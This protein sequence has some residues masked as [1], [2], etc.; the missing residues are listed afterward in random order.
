MLPLLVLPVVAMRVHGLLLPD[1]RPATPPTTRATRSTARRGVVRLA[2]VAQPL[3][4][5][6]QRSLF[7]TTPP[8]SS[9]LPTPLPPLLSPL[10]KWSQQASVLVPQ[11][12]FAVNGWCRRHVL[13]AAAVVLAAVW[14]RR[15]IT[16]ARRRQ[17][18]DMTSEWTRFSRNPGARGAALTVGLLRLVPLVIRA[19]LA[20]SEQAASALRSQAGEKLKSELIKLGPTYVKVGQIV[21]CRDE[22]L[23]KEYVKALSKLQDQVPAFDG[24]AAVELTVEAL[25]KPL[26]SVFQEFD[27]TPLAAASL[28]QVHRAV[29]T[30]EYQSKVV[31]VKVQRPGLKQMYDLD[32]GLLEKMVTVLDRFNVT[33]AGASQRWGDVF[34]EAKVILYREIDYR[35]EAANGERFRSNFQDDDSIIAPATVPELCTEK[36]LVMEYLPGIKAT[37]T[38]A[39]DKAGVNRKKVANNLAKAFMLQFCKH[40]FFN[41]DPHPGN[42]AVDPSNGRLIFYDFGQACSL[43]PLQSAGIQA[44]IESI[45]DLDASACVQAF[46]DMGI[47][48]EGANQTAIEAVVRN[49]FKTGAISS[50]A[51]RRRPFESS[52]SAD[53]SPTAVDTTNNTNSNTSGSTKQGKGSTGIVK[54]WSSSIMSKAEAARASKAVMPDIVLP[55]EYA[56][57]ARAL[58]QMDGVGKALDPDFEFIAAAAPSL[59]E[60]KGGGGVY[61][62][63][64]IEK[65]WWAFVKQFSEQRGWVRSR[66]S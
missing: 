65:K 26:K 56:F 52:A 12:L 19:K 4:Q 40:G 66:S 51:S 27:S 50:K 44:A 53:T 8:L 60:L 55:A 16:A 2:A 38:E 5:L 34:Q 1:R 36:L 62:V 20:R 21:S 33:V 17:A 6:P 64:L 47:L 63:D 3:E 23:P 7:T 46:C 37:D 22:L 59:P 9:L 61:L 49:N 58:S 13:A 18:S 35:D 11:K 14:W 25:G 29:L 57:V 43:E 24:E 31:A 54:A 41:T 10:L 45:I 32:L 48:R 39:L 28:G 30:N 15:D 42:L